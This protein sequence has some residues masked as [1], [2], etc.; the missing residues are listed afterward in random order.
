[1]KILTLLIAFI[2]CSATTYAQLDED[3]ALYL[4][5]VEKYRKM[6]GTGQL[7]TF[8]GS[9]MMI[10]GI[11]MISNSAETTYNSYG[12]QQT[13]SNNAGGGIALYFLGAGAL[14]AGIPLWIVGGINKGR[15]ER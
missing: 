11:V 13:T 5:K 15:Y 2:L 8:G 7:L 3:K 14:G 10:I 1:M 4:K 12:Q 6:K 9:A